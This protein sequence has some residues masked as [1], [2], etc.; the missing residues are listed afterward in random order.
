VGLADQQT[1]QKF[2]FPYNDVFDGLLEI[3][4]RNWSWTLK[5][6]D[7]LLG[8]ITISTLGSLFSYGENI[9]LKLEKV[10]EENT[11]LTIESSL[12]VGMNIAAAGRHAKN[13]DRI[14]SDLSHYLQFEKGERQLDDEKSSPPATAAELPIETAVPTIKPAPESYQPAEE[15]KLSWKWIGAGVAAVFLVIILL[16]FFL[17]VNGRLKR[18]WT[19]T[20]VPMAIKFSPSGEVAVGGLEGHGLEL[21]DAKTGASRQKYEFPLPH[22]RSIAFSSDGLLMAAGGGETFGQGRA[23]VWNL[24]SGSIVRTMSFEQEVDCVD[25]APNSQLLALASSDKLVRLW[26]IQTGS[27]EELSGHSGEVLS[28]VFSPRGG[29]LASAAADNTVRLWDLQTKKTV[30]VLTDCGGEIAFSPDGKIL[31]T[32]AK[33]TGTVKLFEVDTGA[34]RGTLTW[35]GDKYQVRKILFLRN[36]KSLAVGGGQDLDKPGEIRVYDVET[37]NIKYLLTG[38]EGLVTDLAVSRVEPTLVSCGAVVKDQ[39]TVYGEVKVWDINE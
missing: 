39:Y 36:S 20:G 34:Q 23:T 32:G 28:V 27:T 18:T 22:I 37:G 12:K 9:T 30:R 4:P 25:F 31:A 14:I 33:Q 17:R 7:R 8:R 26:D 21:L 19:R 38:H 16:V 2:P 5:S 13:F 11:L 35:A 1:Q 29:T 15:R 3:L 24:Q 10:D 6:H